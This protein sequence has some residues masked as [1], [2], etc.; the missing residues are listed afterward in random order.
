METLSIIFTTL[1][2]LLWNW[3]WVP[4]PFI[5][6]P[7]FIYLYLWWRGDVFDSKIKFV[8]LE[9]NP[10]MEVLK[11]LRAMEAVFTGLWH[12]YDSPNPREKWLEGK[13]LMTMSLELVSVEGNLHF[14]IRVP[15]KLRNLVE[16][17]VYAQY[18][19]V[20][21]T[22]VGD[23]TKNVPDTMPNKYWDLWGCDYGLLKDDVYPIKTYADFFEISSDSKEEKRIDPL[24]PLLE[25]MSKLGRGEQ[26]WVQ[27]M[28][29]PITAAEYDFP[30]KGKIEVNKLVKRP[31]EAKAPS[32]FI[33]K[34]D[35]VNALDLLLM[36]EK[37]ENKKPEPREIMP[38]EMKL[39]PGEREVVAKIENKVSKFSFMSNIRFIYLAKKD[40]FFGAHKAWV[41]GFFDQFASTNLNALKP[42]K[43]TITKV[44]TVSTWFLDK[45]RAYT[46]KRRILRKY[47][48][49]STPLFPKE[50]GT[51]LLNSEELATLFHFPG[52]SVSYAPG[53]KRAEAKKGKAPSNLPVE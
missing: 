23:Y 39:T 27:I 4:L 51:F 29:K 12:L 50:G 43:K 33:G 49:R 52:R 2:D 31:K 19:D 34:D 53:I 35:I 42:W 37:T 25:G 14:F 11:P 5:L 3:W 46:R 17:T 44:H 40:S 9:I 20:D 21:I 6:Y 18:P 8:L 1:R 10:P 38:P 26:L 16:A 32:A 36:G 24:A 28:A 45:R 7:Y 47:I 15:E 48:G 22:E 41:M 13:F 30:K